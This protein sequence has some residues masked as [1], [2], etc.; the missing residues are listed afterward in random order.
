M[1]VTWS[2][3]QLDG[4]VSPLRREIVACVSAR[5]HA[6][7]A[8]WRPRPR[9]ARSLCVRR[10]SAL[11][12]ATVRSQRLWPVISWQQFSHQRGSI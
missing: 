2:D 10:K 3:D 9:P 6:L 8:S 11:R 4:G 12:C 7:A 5:S 1:C